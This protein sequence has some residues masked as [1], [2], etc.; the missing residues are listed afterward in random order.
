M[1]TCP[2]CY[3]QIQDNARFCLYCMTSLEDKQTVEPPLPQKPGKWLLVAGAILLAVAVAACAVCVVL[4][5]G[6]RDTSA[7]SADAAPE[8]TLVDLPDTSSAGEDAPA[9]DTSSVSDTTTRM[10]APST[11]VTSTTT[12]KGSTT[13]DAAPSGS[14]SEVTT[15]TTTKATTT[16]A[17][18]PVQPVFRYVEATLQ[19]AYPTGYSSVY[20]PENAVVI[21]K[22]DYVDPDGQYVIPDT[23]DGKKV[24]AVMPSAFSDSAV[25][26]IVKSVTL[27]ASVRTIWSDAFKG[28]YN[29]TDLYLKSGAIGI[30]TDAFPAVSQR[31]ATLTIHCKRDC[32]DFDFYY[33]RNIAGKYD[34]VYEEWNG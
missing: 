10:P 21:T 12:G 13:A 18:A 7:V 22:V 6:E 2:K 33:Y 4:L 16:T 28:C 14:T 27:P 30:Y 32:R 3:A 23:I 17:Q 29:L 5:T 1:K 11:S 25:A 31:T 9:S 26:P 19:N 24:A 34:A 8:S 20:A 15:T